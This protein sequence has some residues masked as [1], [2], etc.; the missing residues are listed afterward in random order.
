MERGLAGVISDGHT[1]VLVAVDDRVVAVVGVGDPIRPDAAEA[2]AALRRMGHHV[3]LLSGDHPAVV[4]RVAA[5][6]GIPESD[7]RG[8]ATPEE[9]VAYVQQLASSGHVVMV[10]DGVNDTAALAAASVGI[11]VHGGAEASLAAADIYLSRAGLWP[12][13]E[14]MDAARATVGTIRRCFA[15]SLVYNLVASTLAMTGLIGPLT[16]AVLMPLS[17]LT[18]VILVVTARTFGESS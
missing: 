4:A 13:V 11:A 17:S 9:K 3:Q 1:P 14:L 2:V 16:A 10:G 8:A 18:V 15:A 12:I 7:A 5:R 6:A